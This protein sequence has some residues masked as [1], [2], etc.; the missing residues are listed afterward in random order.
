M[1]TTGTNITANYDQGTLT[2]SGIDTV[3][4]YQQVLRTATYTNTAPTPGS[5]RNI[6]FVVD[7]GAVHSNTSNLAATTL[8]LNLSPITVDDFTTTAQDTAILVDV[9]ANDSDPEGGSLTITS[10]EQGLNGTVTHNNNILTYTPNS[11]FSG[12]DSFTYI[13]SDGNSTMTGMVNLEVGRTENAGNGD[14]LV[15]GTPGNDIFHGGNGDDTLFGFAGQDILNGGNGDDELFGGN[16]ADTLTGNNGD[17]KLFGDAGTDILEGNNGDDELFGG[18]DADILTGNNGD[19][20]LFGDAGTDILEGNNGDDE[21][22]GGSNAD[23]LEGNNGDDLLVGGTDADILTGDNGSDT[24]RYY[25]LTDSLLSSFDQIT[26]LKIGTD[27][28]DGINTVS[29]QNVA[30]LGEVIGLDETAILTVLTTND[31]LADG[32]ATFTFGTRTF[33][34]L[35]DN[36]DGF[37]AD[38]DAIIEITGFSNKLDNLA[39]I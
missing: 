17:D 34:A 15:T 18:S 32:A 4:N 36:V 22:F 11:G 26:D 12:S 23:T 29:K 33:V 13:V 35:N 31:F 9:L 20:K 28:I 1:D 25:D 7:D 2:L 6:E 5:Q 38:T 24:F 39:I 16:D 19:D 37:A 10:F 3:A 8:T 14:N 27:F 21:L 30:H